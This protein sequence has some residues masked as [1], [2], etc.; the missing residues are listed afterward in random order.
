MG[1][2]YKIAL[3]TAASFGDKVLFRF[4]STGSL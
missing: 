4:G 2:G 1:E 3:F